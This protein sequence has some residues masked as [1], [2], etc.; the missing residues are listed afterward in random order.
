MDN[1]EDDE[2]EKS[3]EEERPTGIVQPKYKIVHSYPHD[4]MDAWEGHKGTLE[5]KVLEKSKSKLPS[6]L[7]VT[8]TAKHCESMKQAQLDINESTLVFGVEGLY[9]LDLNLKYKVNSE[10]GSAKFDKVRKT[11]TIRL[12]VIDYTEDSRRV[13]D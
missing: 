12:P 8:I 10:E 3:S 1:G 13:A 7:T 2:S 6:E 11:L 5:A 4:I 9:Y